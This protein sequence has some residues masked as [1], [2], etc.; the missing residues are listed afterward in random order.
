MP[1]LALG[2]IIGLLIAILEAIYSYKS[3][4]SPTEAIA[5]RVTSLLP[6]K[7]GALL[8]IHNIPEE[9]HKDIPKGTE[10]D[11]ETTKRSS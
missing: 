9:W 3:K 7:K 10:Y 6:R 1:L 8:K 4:S 11:G 2:I 5:G